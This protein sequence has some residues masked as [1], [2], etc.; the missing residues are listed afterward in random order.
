MVTFSFA[1]K[2]VSI[3]PKHDVKSMVQCV[4]SQLVLIA[5]GVLIVISERTR[6]CPQVPK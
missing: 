4:A 2:K 1:L 5:W 6:A 3:F